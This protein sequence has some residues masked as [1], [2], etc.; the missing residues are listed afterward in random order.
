L[1]LPEDILNLIDKHVDKLKQK[2]KDFKYVD[3]GIEDL[4]KN[5][6]FNAVDVGELLYDRL[7][8]SCYHLVVTKIFKNIRG[9]EVCIIQMILLNILITCSYTW[10]I[11]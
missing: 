7:Y 10:F 8:K 4:K 5:K 6:K 3:E 1:D 11:P 9:L 2:E